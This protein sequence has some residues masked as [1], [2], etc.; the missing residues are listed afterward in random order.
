MTLMV[1]VANAGYSAS[2]L[3][4]VIWIYANVFFNVVGPARQQFLHDPF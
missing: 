2:F 1:R 3:V 4:Q